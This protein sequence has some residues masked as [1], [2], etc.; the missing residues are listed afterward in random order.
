MTLSEARRMPAIPA[1]T[2]QTRARYPDASGALKD[3]VKQEQAL[4]A[5]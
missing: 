5:C 1:P 3:R 2:E 4:A